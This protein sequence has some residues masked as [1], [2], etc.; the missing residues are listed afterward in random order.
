MTA[1]GSL[2]NCDMELRQDEIVLLDESL[3]HEYPDLAMEVLGFAAKFGKRLG[4]HYLLDLIWI[5]KG[6]DISRGMTVL[7][8]G[9]GNGLL[10]YVLAHKGCNVISADMTKRAIP[11]FAPRLFRVARAQ[12][13]RMIAHPYIDHIRA[14]SPKWS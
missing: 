13:V 8:A 14:R 5:L 1:Q 11:G 12:S 2:K 7:D 9:A 4:W 3:I 10:Q 6:L